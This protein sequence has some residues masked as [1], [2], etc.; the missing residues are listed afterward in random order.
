MTMRFLFKRK[1]K[2]APTTVTPP[3][4]DDIVHEIDGR[5][6]VMRPETWKRIQDMLNNGLLSRESAMK[7][8]GIDMGSQRN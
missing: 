3:V 4:T 5:S 7:M 6:M 1:A 2:T 8:A